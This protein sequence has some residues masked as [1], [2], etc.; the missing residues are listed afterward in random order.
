MIV[1][2]AD[3]RLLLI[4]Q[5]DHSRLS[6]RI[7]A[8]CADLAGHPRRGSILLAITEHD[9][10]WVEE[11]AAPN[12][13]A[14]SGEV[15][16]FVRATAEIKHTVWPRAVRHLSMEPWSAALVAQHAITV[17]ERFRGDDAWKTF[18]ATMEQLRDTMRREDGGRMEDLRADYAFVRLGDLISL[19]FCTGWAE[20]QQYDHWQVRLAGSD[21]IVTPDLFGGQRI[22]IEVPARALRAQPY[23]TGQELAGALRSSTPTTLTGEVFGIQDPK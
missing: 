9:N 22:P 2:H 14:R 10:G 17:Y 13:D 18:F 11:D 5:H 16:D 20:E 3:D 4:T 12:V 6:G 21:V 15:V 23:R 1:Q 7:M 19:C 8:R